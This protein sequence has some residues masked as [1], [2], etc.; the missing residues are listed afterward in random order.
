[1]SRG[2]YNGGSSVFGRG[3]SFFSYRKP[4]TRKG[5]ARLARLVTKV[6]GAGAMPMPPEDEAAAEARRSKQL[7]TLNPDGSRLLRKNHPRALPKNHKQK[8]RPEPDKNQSE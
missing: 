4:K 7:G 2:G 3:S 1:M 6:K 5:S 8:L